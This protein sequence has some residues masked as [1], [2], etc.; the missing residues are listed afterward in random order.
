MFTHYSFCALRGR[1]DNEGG[2][3]LVR[4]D[5]RTLKQLA[6]LRSDAHVDPLASNL[7]RTHHGSFRRCEPQTLAYGIG[8]CAHP[9]KYSYRQ[10]THIVKYLASPPRQDVIASGVL[11][12]A[13]DGGDVAGIGAATAAEHVDAR[14]PDVQCRDLDAELVGISIVKFNTFIEF[15]VAES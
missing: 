12:G 15:G 4:Q 13:R 1:G 14:P 11:A 5:R 9:H 8:S 10:C 2:F 7:L 3:A 6:Y